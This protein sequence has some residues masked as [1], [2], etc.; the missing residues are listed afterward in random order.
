M[1]KKQLQCEKALLLKRIGNCFAEADF[2]ELYEDAECR[3]ILEREYHLGLTDFYKL[4][5]KPMYFDEYALQ[6]LQDVRTQNNLEDT[7]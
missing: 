1:T 6:I 5:G 7:E 4:N 2:V 3:E